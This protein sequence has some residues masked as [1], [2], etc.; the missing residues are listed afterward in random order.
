M[1]FGNQTEH[2]Y[3]IKLNTHFLNERSLIHHLINFVIS[4]KHDHFFPC[5]KIIL[6]QGLLFTEAME[7]VIASSQLCMCVCV[8]V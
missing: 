8:C 3:F 6:G 4:L 2:F 7:I 1:P 5:S